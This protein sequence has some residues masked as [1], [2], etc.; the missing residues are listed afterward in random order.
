M[1]TAHFSEHR[2][3]LKL[4]FRLLSSP[5]IVWSIE[6]IKIEWTT[7]DS[8]CRSCLLHCTKRCANRR[9]ISHSIF[10]SSTFDRISNIG[11]CDSL[12]LKFYIVTFILLLCDAF[13]SSLRQPFAI[14]FRR[15]D[16]KSLIRLNAGTKLRNMS[17]KN[18]VQMR[19][20]RFAHFISS[21]A[22]FS[23]FFFPVSN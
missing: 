19:S 1:T 9:R 15:H 22:I 16:N 12:N 5:L 7:R 18:K 8:M 11:Q 10:V 20:H 14:R 13:S 4:N 17:N 3:N 23:L 6:A 21:S 2:R